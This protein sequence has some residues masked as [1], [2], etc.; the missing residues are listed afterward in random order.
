MSI[1]PDIYKK[2]KSLISK[3]MT[4]PCEEGSM[5]VVPTNKAIEALDVMQE[6]VSSMTEQLAKA[7]ERIKEL[8]RE[9]NILDTALVGAERSVEDE[10]K[11]LNKF[12]I[13]MKRECISGLNTYFVNRANREGEMLPIFFPDWCNDF[14]EQLRKEQDQ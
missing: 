9:N 2:A 5:S 3:T 11:A 12:A 14:R 6:E 1:F 7:N 10:I 13:E 4:M 8:E